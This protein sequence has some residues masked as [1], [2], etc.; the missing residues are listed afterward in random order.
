M[1]FSQ[2]DFIPHHPVGT[3]FVYEEEP[4]VSW[5]VFRRFAAWYYPLPHKDFRMD[6]AL[7]RLSHKRCLDALNPMNAEAR[8]LMMRWKLS[9]QQTA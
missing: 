2:S 8:S 6:G 5:T 9:L 4:E 3:V 7:C 1:R